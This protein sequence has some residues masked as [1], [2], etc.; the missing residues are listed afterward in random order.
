MEMPKI[1]IDKY[2]TPLGFVCEKI[3]YKNN[4]NIVD[5]CYNKTGKE[6]CCRTTITK[7]VLDNKWEISFI[8]T[9]EEKRRIVFKNGFKEYPE[10]RIFDNRLSFLIFYDHTDEEEE[11]SKQTFFDNGICSYVNLYLQEK[12]VFFENGVIAKYE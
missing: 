10:I 12:F 8:N 5:R 6:I 9:R 4:I 7:T 3:I 11:I 2:Y 1:L